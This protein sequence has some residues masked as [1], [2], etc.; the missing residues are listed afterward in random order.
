MEANGP[1]ATIRPRRYSSIHQ[2][3]HSLSILASYYSSCDAHQL[4][5]IDFPSLSRSASVNDTCI[6][7]V[8]WSSALCWNSSRL[9]CPENLCQTSA[10]CQGRIHS[11]T[12]NATSVRRFTLKTVDFS[13]R[14][15]CRKYCSGKSLNSTKLR[16]NPHNKTQFKRA[17]RIVE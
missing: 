10:I 13:S 7:R 5:G 15:G 17:L 6:S 14:H 3:V 12:R 9:T 11:H 16:Q 8:N 4:L 1:C 2:L